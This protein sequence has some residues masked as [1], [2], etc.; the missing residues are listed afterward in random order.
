MKLIK[1]NAIPSTNDYLKEL[2]VQKSISDFTIVWAEN[3]T[4]GRGQMG[5][6]WVV[7]ANV[8]L[9]FSILLNGSYL[10]IDRLFLLN[11]IVANSILEALKRYDLE[12]LYIKWPNDILSYSKKIAGIL[13]ENNIKADGSLQSIVGIGIN[14]MQTDFDDLHKAS[15][16]LK[17]YGL[18]IDAEELLRQIVSLITDKVAVFDQIA[19]TQWTYYHD[20]LYKKDLPAAFQLADG[21]TF[22]AI[23]VGVSPDGLLQL[24]KEDDSVF[25]YRLKEVKML[26]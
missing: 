19:E 11:V 13:I 22:M 25:S 8:N 17:N 9:T 6:Q 14:L 23:V 26:Y 5:T 2:A 16:I 21:T 18:R 4:Q 24:K 12:G 20:N 3:Q 7:Q 10:R 1:L 15:S